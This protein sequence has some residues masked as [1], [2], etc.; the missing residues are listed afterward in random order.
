MVNFKILPSKDGAI[1]MRVDCK[2][3]L[4]NLQSKAAIIIQKLEKFSKNLV[5]IC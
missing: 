5:K 2:E 3:P 4:S 1:E